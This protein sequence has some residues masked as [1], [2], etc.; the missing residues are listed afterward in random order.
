MEDFLVTPQSVSQLSIE[1]ASQSMSQLSI[2][3][4]PQPVSEGPQLQP[5]PGNFKSSCALV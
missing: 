1:A 2:E 3:A 4:A 5:A